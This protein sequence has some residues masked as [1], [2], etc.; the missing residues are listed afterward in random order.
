MAVPR[1]QLK[2]RSKWFKKKNMRLKSSRSWQSPKRSLPTSKI[3]KSRKRQSVPLRM[4]A[5]ARLPN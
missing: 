4:I 2:W 3:V 1:G 5:R